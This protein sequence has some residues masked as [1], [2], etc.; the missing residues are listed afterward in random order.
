MKKRYKKAL[1]TIFI[2]FLGVLG[3]STGYGVWTSIKNDEGN[4]SSTT[5]NCFKIYYSNEI[6]EINMG[7]IV[8]ML[9]EEGVETSP[10]TVTIT[11][12]CSEEKEIQLR[13]N[14]MD[15]TTVNIDSLT[16]KVSG[17]IEKDV[18]LFKNLKNVKSNMVGVKNSKLLG[19]VKIPSNSTVRSNIK[20]WFDEK[21]VNDIGKDTILNTRIEI[22]DTDSASKNNFAE[23]VILDHPLNEAQVDYATMV[24][25]GLFKITND[26]GDYYYFRGVVEDN[27]VSFAGH[28]WRIVSIDN[29]QAVKLVYNGNVGNSSYSKYRNAIDYTG[30]K[31]VYNGVA[32]DNQINKFLNSWYE[33]NILDK[34]YDKSVAETNYCNDSSSILEGYH[35]YFGA[36]TRVITNKTPS[37]LCSETSEDFGGLIKQKIAL[38][39]I[40]EVTL[41]GLVDG[42][43]NTTNYLYQA[44]DY[45]TMS[46]AEYYNYTAYMFYVNGAGQ[47][48]RTAPTDIMTIRPVI[49]LD[50][51]LTV[52]GKGTKE[53]P[54]KLE[55]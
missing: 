43:N 4:V 14:L 45:Y 44:N 23:T 36:Y 6:D 5:L 29:N 54:Y 33:E 38:L 25:D 10:Y 32:I 13:L 28:L 49:T 22:I 27:Y 12:I 18:S 3:I 50:S 19:T 7:N 52:V 9:N 20:L 2:L 35:R 37:I 30:L 26:M 40:D 24:G 31:Y 51:S 55:K 53:E 1:L 47:I 11:N 8:P 17:D 21:K 42:V 15:T 46:P 41:S 34:G 39:T 48:L 16:I